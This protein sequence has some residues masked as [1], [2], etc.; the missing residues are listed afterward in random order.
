MLNVS[1]AFKVRNPV[2][3]H[4]LLVISFH[5]NTLDHSTPGGAERSTRGDQK[6]QNVLIFLLLRGLKPNQKIQR[7]AD[8]PLGQTCPLLYV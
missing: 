5:V 2:P 6:F 7:A 4:T 1:V 3:T 8:Q